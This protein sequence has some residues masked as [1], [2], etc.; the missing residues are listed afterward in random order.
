MKKQSL[1][2]LW[3][4]TGFVLTL[5]GAAGSLVGAAAYGQ[6]HPWPED[7]PA[8]A[9]Y[10]QYMAAFCVC[11]GL[12]FGLALIHTVFVGRYYSGIARRAVRRDSEPF[13]FYSLLATAGLLSL[14]LIA[15]GVHMFYAA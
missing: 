4:K 3:L 12:A 9:V 10:V 1:S 2:P 7:T 15:Y 8:P 14:A 11:F 13:H 6:L 5:I